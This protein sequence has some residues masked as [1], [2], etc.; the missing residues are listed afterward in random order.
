MGQLELDVPDHEYPLEAQRTAQLA[1]PPW[2]PAALPHPPTCKA[3][4]RCAGPRGSTPAGA[5]LTTTAAETAT[6]PVIGRLSENRF[7]AQ[8]AHPA[9]Y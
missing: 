9:H 4:R 1:P 2:R 3:P 8:T 6:R 7:F 5:L